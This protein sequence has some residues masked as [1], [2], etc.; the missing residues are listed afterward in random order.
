MSRGPP[1]SPRRF[2]RTA[3]GADRAALITRGDAFEERSRQM[4]P[5]VEGRAASDDCVLAGGEGFDDLA[6][7]RCCRDDS[8]RPVSEPQA[9]HR[10]IEGVGL[11]RGGEL[12][13]PQFHVLLA[14]EPVGLLGREQLAHRAVRP[15]EPKVRGEEVGAL[16]GPAAGKNAGF[17]SHHDVAR[18]GDG[19]AD[20]VDDRVGVH[21]VSHRLRAG[22]RLARAAPGED[23]PDDPVAIRRSLV[24][25]GP[26]RPVMKQLRAFA[27]RHPRTG[28]RACRGRA[29]ENRRR[30][31]PAAW[32][33]T[34]MRTPSSGGLR[35]FVGH[36]AG[37]SGWSRSAIS[38]IFFRSRA[39][40][41]SPYCSGMRFALVNRDSGQADRRFSAHGRSP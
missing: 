25:A 6:W 39:R 5:V 16:V 34:R 20:E 40:S 26:E 28:E 18:V 22:P 11:A 32:N 36:S 33:E 10:L 12:V 2:R 41:S 1:A 21:P 29:S 35:R 3:P 7:A 19:G 17:A 14:P 31:D 30:A 13:A 38:L 24:G 27:R 9:Q 4:S 8:L 37:S 23:E 15:F